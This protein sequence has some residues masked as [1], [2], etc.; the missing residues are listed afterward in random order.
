[1]APVHAPLPP[2]VSFPAL[3]EEVLARWRERDVYRESLRRREGA[4]PYVFYE[5]PPTANGRPGSH[6]VLAR[7]FKDVFP[8]YKTMR[9]H[10]V[11]RKG[12]WDCH[13]LPVELEVERQLGITQKDQIEEYGVAEFNQQ[14]RDSVHRYVEDWSSLLSLVHQRVGYSIVPPFVPVKSNSLLTFDLPHA[15]VPQESYYA[16]FRPK[17]KK[18]PS[19]EKALGF[20]VHSS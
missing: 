5:G 7:V 11:H 18:I 6:H 4:P 9:G 20:S 12:G 19:F 17:L 13:G 2:N 1:M 3:E 16:Q 10:L 14:C 8:R 15:V